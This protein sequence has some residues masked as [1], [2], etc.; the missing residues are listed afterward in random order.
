MLGRAQGS[1]PPRPI[2][3]SLG[4]HRAPSVKGSIQ[5]LDDGRTAGLIQAGQKGKGAACQPVSWQRAQAA[6]CRSGAPSAWP[7]GNRSVSGRLV[8]LSRLQ[9]LGLRTATPDVHH[10]GQGLGRA[11]PRARSGVPGSLVTAA[12]GSRQASPTPSAR[13]SSEGYTGHFPA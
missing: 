12:T 9:A 10:D 8:V 3:R 1:T 13:L 6:N 4:L 11:P 2:L 5:W 7:S